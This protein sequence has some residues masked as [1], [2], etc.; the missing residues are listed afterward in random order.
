MKTVALYSLKGGVGKTTMAVNLAWAAATLSARKTLLWDLDPQAGASFLLGAEPPPAN[1]ARAAFAREVSLTKLIRPTAIDRL[2]VIAADRSLRGLNRFLD[3]LHKKGRLAK[4]LQEV[5]E[6]FDRVFLDCPPGLTET[7]E[8]ILRA[9]DLIVVPVIPSPLSHRALEEVYDHLDRRQIARSVVFPFFN[10]VDR[11]RTLH[12]ETLE[13]HP[14]WPAVP[15]ASS[16]EAMSAQRCPI[17][18][19]PRSSPAAAGLI[20]LWRRIERRLTSG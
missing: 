16:F 9:A 15:M 17:G 18:G 6:Q 12:A 10:M 20:A 14:R 11:R 2:S 19:M 4:L 13:A 8:Q 5:K 7:T 3:E 1:E